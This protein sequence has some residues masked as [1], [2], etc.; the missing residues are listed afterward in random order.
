MAEI[1]TLMGPSNIESAGDEMLEAGPNL[2]NAVA[3][4]QDV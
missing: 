4:S 3:V 2:D 1:F